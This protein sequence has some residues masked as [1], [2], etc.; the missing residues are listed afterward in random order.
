MSAIQNI[1]LYIPHIFANYSK[2][3]VAWVF[4]DHNIGKVKNIDF[5]SK[6]GQ[7]GKEFNAAYIHFDYWFDNVTASNFQERVLNPNKEARLMY[8]DPWY[9]IVLENRAR[10]VAPGDRKPRIDLGEFPALSVANVTPMKTN[11]AKTCPGAPMK[12]KGERQTN[13]DTVNL[14]ADFDED[15]VQMNEIEALIEEEER[16][17]ANFDSRYVETLEA[18]NMNLRAQLAWFQNALSIEQIKS[19]ALAEAFGKIKKE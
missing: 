18:E 5:I 9:W 15:E 8:E 7:D 10:K 16:Y 12:A 4:E 6:I 14:N 11:E 19:Q 2:D 1:S 3:D 13:A 17:L